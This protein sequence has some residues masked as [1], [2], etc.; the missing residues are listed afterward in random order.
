MTIIE[1]AEASDGLRERKKA[2]TRRA[3]HEAAYRLVD[4]HGLEGTTIDQICQEADVSS[5]TFFNYFPSK[6]AAALGLPGETIDDGAVERFRSATGSLVDALC[7]MIAGS[8]QFVARQRRLKDLVRRHPELMPALGNMMT[9]ARGR[10][11]ELAEVRA[12]RRADAELAVTLVLAALTLTMHSDTESDLPTAA[13]LIAA[14]DAIVAVRDV[15]MERPAIE[16][17]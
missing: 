2:Q 7:S 6:N 4:E 13:R 5:R 8:D 11:V 10:L 16:Q 17:I 3:I 9:A 1:G 14:V 15:P 12:P